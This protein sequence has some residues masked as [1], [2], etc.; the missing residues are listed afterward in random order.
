VVQFLEALGL[1]NVKGIL[2]AFRVARRPPA[3][4]PVGR[5]VC[6]QNGS[7]LKLKSEAAF[8]K[9]NGSLSLAR[10]LYQFGSGV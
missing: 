1:P 10:A 8:C 4:R 5:T 7:D 3:R 2:S 9:E 6:V